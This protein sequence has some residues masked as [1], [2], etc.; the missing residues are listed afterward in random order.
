MG[1]TN[2]SLNRHVTTGELLY[3]RV[4]PTDTV[5]CVIPKRKHWHPVGKY[6]STISGRGPVN[7]AEL[8]GVLQLLTVTTLTITQ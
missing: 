3:V 5:T 1:N 7:N 2:V 4:W 8:C 6:V